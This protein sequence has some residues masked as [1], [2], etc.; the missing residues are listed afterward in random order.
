MDDKSHISDDSTK[1]QLLEENLRLKHLLQQ[2]NIDYKKQE[3]RV[4]LDS[5][6]F[7]KARSASKLAYWYYHLENGKLDC[8]IE[9]YKILELNHLEKINGEKVLQ[10]I[11]PESL[12]GFVTEMKQ[13]LEKENQ[14]DISTR[15]VVTD[16]S[17]K[18]LSFKVIVERDEQN[19]P[20]TISG[21]VADIT[22]DYFTFNNLKNNEKLFRSLFINLTDIFII[23]EVVKDSDGNITDYIYKDVN[24][25]YEMKVGKTKAEVI[26]KKLSNQS[27][28]FQQLSPLLQLSVIA[29]QPQQDRLY[30]Q[31]LDS[32]FDILIYSP[33]ENNLATIW[34]DVT[35]MVEAE[36]SLRESE[37][38]YRQIFSIGSDALFMFDFLSGRIIDVNPTGSSLFGYSKFSLQKM[39]FTQLSVTPEKLKEEI[40][41]E[42][43]LLYDF[44][45]IKND[46]SV[47][48]VEVSLSY[49]NWSGRKVSIASVR[50]I[51]ERISAQENL[52][53][54]EQK[55]KQLFNFSNDAILIIKNYHIIEFN[56][57]S[58]SLFG[59]S[60]ENLSNN[61]LWNLSPS[62][63]QGNEDSRAKAVEYIQ[64]TLLGN[65]LQFEWVFKLPNQSTFFAD[66]KL[67]PII[68]GKDKLVQVIV[69]DI[70]PQK[71]SQKELIMR[72][73]LWKSALQT[74]NTGIVDWNVINNEVF[75]SP[76][77]EKMLGY[78]E[79][80]LSP[81]IEEYLNRVH[82]DD[83]E[84]LN[85]AINDYLLAKSNQFLFEYRV[86]CKNG[87]YKWLHSKGKIYSY[88][89]HGKVER[90]IISNIDITKQKIQAEKT[91]EEL[92]RYSFAN[93][94]S[95]LGYWELDIKTM[96]VS[97]NQNTFSI[98]GFDNT[99]QLSLRQ[100][101]K[102]IH[103]EDQQNFIGQFL[104]KTE[105]S[106]HDYI[107]RIVWGNTTQYILSRSRP[108]RNTKNI[109][110]GFKGT[111]QNI[112]TLKEDTVSIINSKKLLDNVLDNLHGAIQVV[113]D[114]KIIF[115]NAKATD[116][117][118][119][120]S[121]DIYNQNIT[122]L[123]ITVAEDVSMVKKIAETV[124]TNPLRRENAEVRI[125]T[126]NG[127]F[128]WI[129]LHVSSIE[130]KNSKALLYEF[131]DISSRKK[132]EQELQFSEKQYKSIVYNS[133]TAIAVV[134]TKREIIFANNAFETISG[135]G[136][137]EIK[138][139]S[140]DQIF[141]K[142]ETEDITKAITEILQSG[143]K[144]F[145]SEF[146]QLGNN[147]LMI[148][149]T[150][151]PVET[152]ENEI[153]YLIFYIE[154]IEKE[155]K[156]IL[157][158]NE[159]NN[160][161]Q[162]FSQQAPYGFAIANSK[163]E[164]LRYNPTFAEDVNLQ[165][166]TKVTL[167]EIEAIFP[168]LNQ[169]NSS[170]IDDNF[171]IAYETESSTTKNLSIEIKGQT[172]DNEKLFFIYTSD[173]TKKKQHTD[174]LF[175]Q[176]ERFKGIFDNSPIGI[177]LVDK[178]RN[179]II[180]NHLFGKHL[181]S[182]SH[183]MN[184][185]KID[186]YIDTQ[187]LNEFISQFAQL[188]TGIISSFQQTIKPNIPNNE[189]QWIAASISIVKDSFGDSRYAIMVVDDIS[190]IKNDEKE[191]VANEKILTLRYVGQ[192]FGHQF[193][194]LM[195]G[196]YGNAY[197]LNKNLRN[198]Q[199]SRYSETLLTS[200]SQASEL[201]HK[202]LLFS[203]KNN[204][205]NVL[206]G[207]NNL[208]NEIISSIK[209]PQSITLQTVLNHKNEVITG[210]MSQLK[211]ALNYI[212]ENAVESMPN[213]GQLTIETSIAYFE[214]EANEA[215]KEIIKGKY[216]RIV[217][218]DTG[219]GIA[220]QLISKIF[221]PF[222][223]TKPSGHNIGLGLPMA[224][225]IVNEH[226]GFIKVY[227]TPAQGSSFNIYLPI[228]DSSKN[229]TSIQPD[230]QRLVKGS[231][232]I[233]LIDDE[234]IVRIIT[235]ELLSELGYD[236]YSFASGKNALTFYKDNHSTIN[237]VLLDK[238][239]PDMDGFE[240]YKE[241]KT[242]NN[243]VK[244]VLLTGLEI[245]DEIKGLFSQNLC[246]CIQKPVSIEK[247]SSSIAEAL[248][249]NEL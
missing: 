104:S 148:R 128:K 58:V 144:Q 61:T 199:L 216:L 86:R 34:R 218:S 79:G 73:E 41:K 15:F 231:A 2:Y 30:I 33:S 45:F 84:P 243:E 83:L 149:M 7:Q 248:Y 212:L 220:P 115:T 49:F 155:A 143:S 116:I 204:N 19:K 92:H 179:I 65:Q 70:S 94:I 108:V 39:L 13:K 21:T 200:T 176:A 244:V 117:S 72:E 230:E 85:R 67:S 237:L 37:E 188:F 165:S 183:K 140:L 80:E 53:K 63:Q 225:K 60:A 98:L 246:G 4:S 249:K 8:T 201:T 25:S 242:I 74:S 55:F 122:P 76:V 162:R 95:Q 233:L 203:E 28:L 32:F 173:I 180:S 102:T 87:T 96:I 178:N 22:E 198:T 161:S 119:H 103:P 172:I 158:L 127:R 228:I 152:K 14:F 57:K 105:L 89:D 202:L 224:K 5:D 97:G 78:E 206:L 177:V 163:N 135:I 215:N 93:S 151:I 168:Y 196:I 38:K 121:K 77:F 214:Q 62:K 175:Y 167:N 54:S 150:I 42:K 239:M 189:N 159:E 190:K 229:I 48:P 219:E 221:D 164:V 71:A 181:G 100:I 113:L 236:V 142:N 106:A 222:F 114:G 36:S 44:S 187:Y 120:Q 101:E 20:I 195:M 153:D 169:L 56:Q 47:F 27:A 50:D 81:K 146:D 207:S 17:V 82:T 166:K 46:L 64:S 145:V 16:G 247:L 43:T 192:S 210:D 154:D 24:P 208:I 182:E 160:I 9:A 184:F 217:V 157:A 51:S 52:V 88:N 91:S 240:V 170:L 147:K 124:I 109:L 10:S 12:E 234:E 1:K 223:S 23:L 141:S 126:K 18:F 118:G 112:S 133:R 75:F 241:M 193:N 232:K 123:S 238:H 191:L 186:S 226:N 245:D 129:K 35:L 3:T 134:N 111:F 156:T 137:D 6:I 110:T 125:E 197:L 31:Q 136:L 90:V 59:I 11:H 194:N 131:I 29:G 107:F 40:I 132:A 213:S 227:S 171:H 26:Q 205:L 185:T 211:R 68:V 209:I 235:A 138:S 130:I 66:I 69:R 99:E 139:K 174:N